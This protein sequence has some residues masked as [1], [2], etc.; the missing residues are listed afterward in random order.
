MPVARRREG[1]W[2]CLARDDV[3]LTRP[4]AAC[5]RE[6]RREGENVEAVKDIDLDASSK[7]VHEVN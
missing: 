5:R 6:R 7:S 3:L 4:G 1:F 2:L